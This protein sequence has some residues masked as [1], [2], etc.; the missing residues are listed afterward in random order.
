MS[1]VHAAWVLVFLP[2]ALNILLWS[3]G[4]GFGV[5]GCVGAVG[6][7]EGVGVGVESDDGRCGGDGRALPS[8]G[9][10]PV[11]IPTIIVSLGTRHPGWAF[12]AHITIWKAS[13]AI[14]NSYIPLIGLC[15]EA[16][17]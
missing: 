7:C 17:L 15:H 10:A 13:P 12:S 5:C 4:V 1:V 3:G 8:R 11:I 9:P 2:N 16:V 6:V 14:D